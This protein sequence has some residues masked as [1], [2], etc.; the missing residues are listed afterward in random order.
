MT[1]LEMIISFSKEIE[2]LKSIK[3]QNVTLDDMRPENSAEHSW[4]LAMMA[5]VSAKHFNLSDG[6]L[7]R[8][9]KMLLVHDL[10]EIY[11][12]DTFLYD[13]KGKES[14]HQKEEK[15]IMKLA[16]I[17]PNEE[18]DE[19]VDLWNEFENGDTDNARFA[20]ALDGLQPLINRVITVPDGFNPHGLRENQVRDKKKFI[21]E[22]VAELGKITDETIEL[23]V[24]KGHY[25]RDVG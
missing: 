23:S 19:I 7:L 20:L 25:K 22:H 9:L 6:S 10:G 13:E 2:K 15:A 18:K 8:I 3:R 17:L 4:H 24:Q 16:S 12:G 1:D 11:D 5:M 14:S 21:G